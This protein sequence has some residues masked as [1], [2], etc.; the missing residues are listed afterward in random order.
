[1]L[2]TPAPSSPG[3]ASTHLQEEHSHLASYP[4]PPHNGG[5]AP[6]FVLS[7]LF[8]KLQ[9]ERK[10]EKRRKLLDTWFNVGGVSSLK[11]S[12]L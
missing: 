2:A 5:S 4:D 7:A 3:A 6:F 9:N 8:D 11:L 12:P 10:P 1:M